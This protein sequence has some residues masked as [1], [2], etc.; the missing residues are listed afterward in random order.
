MIRSEVDFNG[1]WPGDTPAKTLIQGLEA[2]EIARST[3]VTTIVPS[4][5]DHGGV[6]VTRNAGLLVMLAAA[7]AV[8][9]I[10]TGGSGPLTPG[11]WAA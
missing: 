10:A 11:V 2:E 6:V 4:E 9:T 1:G 8:A 5:G 7:G 3:H